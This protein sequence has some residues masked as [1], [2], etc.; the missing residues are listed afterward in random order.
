MGNRNFGVSELRNP[1]TDRL[2]IWHRR[3]RRWVDVLGRVSKK[4]AAQASTTSGQYGQMYCTPRLL[5]SY[6]SEGHFLHFSDDGV[7]RELC[8]TNHGYKCDQFVERIRL[9]LAISEIPMSL[10]F[11]IIC[12]SLP[13]S[14][15]LR[16]N[17][18]TH[19]DVC[20]TPGPHSWKKKTKR[21]FYGSPTT[22]L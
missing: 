20:I 3:L 6:F 18:F 15:H 2:T 13:Y 7:E 11:K 14:Q 21:V 4:S 19:N 5:F 1:W 10:H 9:W 22:L 17:L 8:G 12:E 16:L